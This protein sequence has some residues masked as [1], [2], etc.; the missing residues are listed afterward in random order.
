MGPQQLSKE[1]LVKRVIQ[2]SLLIAVSILVTAA[3][4]HA[5]R[6]K[7]LIGAVGGATTSDIC[8][9]INTSSRWGGTAGLFA[10]FRPNRQTV[11]SLEGLW[12]QKGGDP[13]RLDYVEFPLTFGASMP[14][15][16]GDWRIR[17]YTGIGIGFK[18]GCSENSST[19]TFDCDNSNST[20]WTWPFGIVF[21]HINPNGSMF[22]FDVRYSYGLSNTFDNLNTSRNRTW[23]FRLVYGLP[24]GRG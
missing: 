20:E 21:S 13:V 11:V 6:A 3:P 12:T 1:Q 18:I 24:M 19:S 4:G 10:A 15:G 8:C 22:G 14:T 23:Y 16:N 2:T 7:T 5:Q 9:R 17:A